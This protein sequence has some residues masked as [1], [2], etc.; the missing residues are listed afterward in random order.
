MRDMQPQQGDAAAL[1]S[2]GR[3]CRRWLGAAS[4]PAHAD[5]CASPS[6]AAGD[7]PAPPINRPGR[8]P[9]TTSATVLRLAGMECSERKPEIM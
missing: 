9:D 4:C 7:A 8:W 2:I 6:I 5:C 3:W 1:S